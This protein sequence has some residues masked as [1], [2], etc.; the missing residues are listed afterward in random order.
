MPNDY[1]VMKYMFNLNK[2]G[3]ETRN[4]NLACINNYSRRLLN[5]FMSQSRILHSYN[6]AHFGT[7]GAGACYGRGIMG[8]S[9][10]NYSLVGT[11]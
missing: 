7:V 8:T 11:E 10:Q 4:L 9:S 2:K 6:L 1:S 3:V 5:V